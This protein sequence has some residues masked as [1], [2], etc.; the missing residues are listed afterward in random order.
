M[1]KCEGVHPGSPRSGV[2][3]DFRACFQGIGQV[4]EPSWIDKED[5]LGFH[6]QLLARFGGLAGVR[7]EGLL[8]SALGRPLQAFHYEKCAR[9]Q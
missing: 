7:D 8:E 9:R 3:F 5:C 6:E 1:R 4:N 2:F